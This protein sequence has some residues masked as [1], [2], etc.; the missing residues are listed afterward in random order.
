MVRTWSFHCG[1]PGSKPSQKT[2][3]L[4]ALGMAIKEKENKVH[5]YNLVHIIHVQLN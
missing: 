5:T 4:Q 1:G 3:I 2:K